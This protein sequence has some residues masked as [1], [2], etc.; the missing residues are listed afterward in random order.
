VT[1]R[2]FAS[3]RPTFRAPADIVDVLAGECAAAA[4]AVLELTGEAFS[5]PTR[6]E[7]WDVRALL[8]H[9]WRD[10]DRVVVYAAGEPPERADSDAV[11]YYRS[12]YDPAADAADV[13]RRAVEAA[14]AFPD[15][16]ALAAGFDRRWRE[17]VD[18]ARSLPPDRLVRTF[19]PC[20]RLDEYLCTR[21]LE[22][23]VHGLDLTDA[24]GREP[25]ITPR[26][27]EVVRAM[28]VGLLETEPPVELEWDDLAFLEAGTGRRALTDRE[29]SSLGASADRFPLLA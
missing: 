1:P 15:G 24:L 17:A 19:G 29:R 4:R 6:C 25:W 10:V 22:A 5:L 23:A 9:L 27:V 20:L 2:T 12:G 8:G 11:A 13:A 21:L 18:V 14:D 16:R 26:A 7:A 3:F 28:L